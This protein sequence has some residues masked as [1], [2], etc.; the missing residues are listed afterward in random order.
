[1]PFNTQR[2]EHSVIASLG[3][4]LPKSLAAGCVAYAGAT[5]PRQRASAVRHLMTTLEAEAGT[6]VGHTIMQ[7]CACIGQG[8]I[9]RAL[10]VQQEAGDLE[11]L[12]ARLN[13][14]H[15]GGGYLRLEGDVIHAT[16]DHCYCGSV[17]RA[18][19]PIPATY[20]ACSCGW[21]AR[22]FE[23]LLG[24]PV[25]V[26]LLGSIIQGDAQCGFAIRVPK[27]YL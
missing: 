4:P 24:Q 17:N 2:F 14:V 25:E 11:D 1:M 13:A 7:R 19:E 16:Y 9:D 6:E 27:A 22:L 20:C 26:E 8:V 23:A 3:H 12:L 15:I 10:A 21:Y 18:T 5:T